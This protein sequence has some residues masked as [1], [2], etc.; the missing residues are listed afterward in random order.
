MKEPNATPGQIA[1]VKLLVPGIDKMLNEFQINTLAENLEFNLTPKRDYTILVKDALKGLVVDGMA[2]QKNLTDIIIA[3]NIP[4]MQ[5]FFDKKIE[6]VGWAIQGVG[7]DENFPTFGYTVGMCKSFGIELIFIGPLSFR[8]I[9]DIINRYGDLIK[10]KKI[11]LDELL[12]PREDVLSNMGKAGARYLSKLVKANAEKARYNYM[13]NRRGEDFD[14]YQILI[15]DVNNKFP[16]EE[17][18]DENFRQDPEEL[19]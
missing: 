7:A 12:K 8:A 11:P 5:D 13:N 3:I 6:E 4:K 18:Y 1:T 16:G 9:E 15:Q 19:Q 14:V 17:G 2:D 10:H